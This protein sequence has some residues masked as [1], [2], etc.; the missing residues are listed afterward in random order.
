MSTRIRQALLFAALLSTAAAPHASAGPPA[1]GYYAR[2]R[3]EFAFDDALAVRLQGRDFRGA[4][5]WEAAEIE[6]LLVQAGAQDWRRLFVTATP[7]R[8]DELRAKGEARLGFRLPDLNSWYSVALADEAAATALAE[9]LS[10]H[11]HLRQVGV[12]PLPEPHAVDILPP[13]PLFFGAQVYLYQAPLGV[14]A[15]GAWSRPGGR[16]QGISVVH[17]EGG[18]ILDHEDLDLIHSGGGNS[19]LPLWYNHGTACTT[20]IGSPHNNYGVSGIAPELD[21][22]FA[23]GIFENGSAAAWIAS[24]ELLEPG[25]VISASWGFASPPPPGIVCDPPGCFCGQLGGLPAE[26]DPANFE[27]IQTVTAAGYLVICS[28]AN[29]LVNLD[30]PWYGGAYDLNQ[31]DSGALLIGA[32]TAQREPICFSNHGS[33]VDACSYGELMVAGGY[34]DLF[35]GGDE[36]RQSYTDG[37]GG[38]SAACPIVSGAVAVL[39]GVWKAANSGSTLDAWQV[40]A[41]LRTTGTLPGGDGSRPVGRMPDLA[42]LLAAIEGPLPDVTAPW[43]VH[44]PLPDTEGGSGP[45]SLSATIRDDSGV[46]AA[47]LR[48]RIHGGIWNTAPLQPAGGDLWTGEIPDQGGPAEVEYRLIATDGA[49]PANTRDLGWSFSLSGPVTGIAI[50]APTQSAFSQG[51]EWVDALQAAGYPG[52]IHL[53]DDLGVAQLGEWTDALLVLLGIFPNRHLVPAGGPD[54]LAIEAYLAAGGKALMEGGDCWAFDPNLGG[55]DFGPAFGVVGLAD[56][57]GDLAVAVG[58][59]PL[60]GSFAYN[61]ANNWIDRLGSAGAQLLLRNEAVG[62]DCGFYQAGE[63]I[64]VAASCELAGLEDFPAIAAALFGPELF[65]LLPQTRRPAAVSG[66]QITPVDT[67][68]GDNWLHF[69]LWF[70]PVT[71]DEQGQPLLVEGYRLYWSFEPHAPFPQGWHHTASSPVNEF[72]GVPA[73]IAVQPD[74]YL[75]VTAVDEDGLLTGEMPRP[76]LSVVGRPPGR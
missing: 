23:H 11:P 51:G 48:W 2:P 53:L 41:L 3:V 20:I 29:G 40:R 1:E 38:T 75:R 49:T 5:G 60:S 61:G 69:D 8:L 62:Y 66:L 56:G 18:W 12:A 25:D 22:V 14:G 44:E 70:P 26:S 65:D 7:G 31:R 36:I 45:W 63:S 35:L 16:G 13:T 42:Q 67:D 73:T 74:L 64:T 50:W 59:P 28:A 54:A 19:S 21:E 39:Q 6:R 37:F 43:I 55:H 71:Q 47:E 17:C 15:I 52:P 9:Q 34:G 57:T 10:R 32:L 33:R 24:A 46:S 76:G 72:L 58:H 30:D 68:P 27:A 4:D